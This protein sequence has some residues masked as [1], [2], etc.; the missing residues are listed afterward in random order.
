[1]RLNPK[2]LYEGR[3]PVRFRDAEMMKRALSGGCW[4]CMGDVKAIGERKV[5]CVMCECTMEW[6][7]PTEDGK[8]EASEV[9][10]WPRGSPIRPGRSLYP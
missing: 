1:M 4:R 6:S 2:G 10:G 5:V 3:V 9:K 8:F 7:W